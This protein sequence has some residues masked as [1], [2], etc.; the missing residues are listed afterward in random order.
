MKILE[1]VRQYVDDTNDITLF[2][3][4]ISYLSVHLTRKRS[5]PASQEPQVSNVQLEDI[6]LEQ[7]NVECVL[8]NL[9]NYKAPGPDDIPTRLFTETAAEIFPS[10]CALFNKSNK[11]R[12]GTGRMEI[13]EHRASLQKGG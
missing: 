2:S 7:N 5:T 9:D 4:T 1:N 12:C 10:I 3:T 8:R 6:E 11:N 13:D